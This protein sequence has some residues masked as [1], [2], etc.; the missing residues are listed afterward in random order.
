MGIIG[1]LVASGEAA[2]VND[3]EADARAV[4]VAGTPRKGEERLMVAPLMAGATVK[5]AM[6]LWRTAGHPFNDD[7]LAFLVSLSRQAAV[8]IENARLFNETREALAR[9]TATSDVLRAM[10]RSP[11]DTRPVFE[12]ILDLATELCEAETGL[13]FSYDGDKFEAKA[14]KIPTAAFAA[15]F[16]QPLR[17]NPIPVLDASCAAQRRSTSPTRRRRRLPRRRSASHG[18]GSAGGVRAWLAVPMIKDGS[19]VGAI[20]VYRKEM[21]PFDS[22]QIEL[23]STFADQAVIA[24]EN[25]RLFNET[26]EALEQQRASAEVLAAISNS[27]ADTR[28]VFDT[29]VRGCERLFDGHTVGLMLVRDGMLA[30]GAWSGTGPEPQPKPC[31]CRSTTRPYRGA[32]CSND[33]S[34]SAPTSTRTTCRSVPAAWP[35][36]WDCNRSSRRRCS[37]RAAASA[38][39]GSAGRSRA[40]SATST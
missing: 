25:V 22:R 33:A 37:S 13:V 6:A 27:I 17:A 5:G 26:K 4:Q 9:Q 24:I 10:S 7:E 35:A 38:P 32:R 39:C 21:R 1:H 23:L 11:T 34:S 14:R 12:A 29:I 2:Y 36:S 30:I 40:R 3:T 28:P 18:N 31:W 16:D 19:V 20:V 15:Y 8:A